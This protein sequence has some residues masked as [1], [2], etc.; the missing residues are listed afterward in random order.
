MSLSVVSVAMHLSGLEAQYFTSGDHKVRWLYEDGARKLRSVSPAFSVT[1]TTSSSGFNSWGS[2]VQTA[3][4]DVTIV[5]TIPDPPKIEFQKSNLR[6]KYE[7]R[8][9]LDL[10]SNLL[11]SRWNLQHSALSKSPLNFFNN[12]SQYSRVNGHPIPLHVDVTCPDCD[13]T[14]SFFD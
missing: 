13:F 6:I 14:Q 2:D 7:D 3:K 12:R 5:N 9:L 8:Q 10:M 4:E 11:D 1:S